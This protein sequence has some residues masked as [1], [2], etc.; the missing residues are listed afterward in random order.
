LGIATNK[1]GL[2]FSFVLKFIKLYAKINVLRNS[3]LV[4]LKKIN[5]KC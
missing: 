3:L 1:S 5:K 2:I 4:L